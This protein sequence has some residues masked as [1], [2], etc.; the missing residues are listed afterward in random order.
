MI[1][2]QI[3]VESFSQEKS[4]F[5]PN[6]P[7]SRD[8]GNNPSLLLSNEKELPWG[9]FSDN[10]LHNME[11]L[12]SNCNTLS[13]VHHGHVPSSKPTARIPFRTESM[14][15]DPAIVYRNA[16]LRPVG[17]TVSGRGGLLQQL[18]SQRCMVH[19]SIHSSIRKERTLV[20][21]RYRVFP[22]RELNPNPHYADHPKPGRYERGHVRGN[23]PLPLPWDFGES[24]A[25][26]PHPTTEGGSMPGL[27]CC[28]P[29]Q[30]R[31]AKTSIICATSNES[32]VFSRDSRPGSG[33]VYP[34]PRLK[35]RAIGRENL[36]KQKC[37]REFR[38][39]RTA[40]RSTRP[41]KNDAGPRALEALTSTLQR[42]SMDTSPAVLFPE[43]PII[44]FTPETE[45][46]SCGTRLLVQK[47]RQKKV[48]K[49]TGPIM[50]HETVTKC[51]ECGNVFG[52]DT[53]LQWVPPRSNVAYDVMVSVGRAMYQ[54]HRTTEEIRAEL[55]SC[56]V[57]LSPSEIHY[58]GRRFILYLARAHRQAIPR[59][60]EAMVMAGGYMLHLD[61]THAGNAPALMTGLDS[62]SKIVLANIKIPSEHSDHIIPFLEDIKEAYGIPRAC[63]HDMGTGIC[64]AVN[65]VFPEVLDVICHFH[66]LRDIG[67]DFLDPAYGTLRN[68][69]RS[70]SISSKLSALVR[71]TRQGACEQS[72]DPMD[73]AKALLKAKEIPPLF[74]LLSAY[75]LALWAL[76]GKQAGDGYG[77]PFDRPLLSFAERLILLGQQM[78][79]LIDLSKN[80]ASNNIQYLYKLY[81]AAAEVAEDPAVITQ[82]DELRWRTQ[83]FDSLRKAMRIALPGGSDGL[84]DDG[85]T[86]A[87]SSIQEAVMRFR[88][89][90][91]QDRKLASD[92]LCSK[93][94][95]QID[96][97]CDK[98]FAG[99]IQVDTPAGPVIIY[100]QRTNNILEQ[101]FRELNRGNRR[102]TGNNSMQ[103]LLKNMLVDTPLIKNLDNPDY[104][105][106]LLGDK[107]NL[108]EL[109]ASMDPISLPREI[110]F[111]SGADRILPGFRKIIRLA[112]LPDRLIQMAANDKSH[113]RLAS[114]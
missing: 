30:S 82:V 105:A 95:E 12:I 21:S 27:L 15:D 28:R 19:P 25:Q 79:R 77:F 26:G 75:G 44:R 23:A 48:F 61:A 112:A 83:I 57:F 56:N 60:R 74:P 52:S 24:M 2:R 38:T 6:M 93:M 96:K 39:N 54:R 22:C 9:T 41:K 106:L 16:V 92:P 32:A 87:I 43:P 108:E 102:K 110:E 67:K 58:L 51:P 100:P 63:V 89:R 17:S 109:F 7:I 114:N 86:Q 73:L 11:C 46:C 42:L 90:I 78:P 20:L 69:L 91:D 40:F 36:Q 59:M 1:L 64:K 101:F 94:A 80:D 4:V 103:R 3:P 5:Y 66:F 70:H 104:M 84:N 13:E 88:S 65:E 99:P 8:I 107:A 72:S 33:R 85:T 34:Q 113:H 45:R 71:E 14:L 97:Y 37:D 76:D 18:F 62:L 111:Q 10:V 98:L 55:A 47:T 68:L 31:E 29:A 53:L 49:M 50:A 35:L 81:W